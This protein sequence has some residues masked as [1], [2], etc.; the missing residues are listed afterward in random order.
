MVRPAVTSEHA[1]DLLRGSLADKLLGPVAVTLRVDH[2]GLLA[3]VAAS[4][5]VGLAVARNKLSPL[6]DTSPDE[7]VGWIAPVLRHLTGAAPR[8]ATPPGARRTP[9]C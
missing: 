3:A 4:E 5:L 2:P 7:L 8:R 6:A 1:A 9:A